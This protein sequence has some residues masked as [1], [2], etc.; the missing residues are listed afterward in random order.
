MLVTKKVRLFVDK[1]IHN[2]FISSAGCSRFSYNWAKNFSDEYYDKNS[3]TISESEIRKEFTIFKKT[4]GIEWINDVDNDILKQS[5]RDFCKARSMFF[6]GIH[7]IPKFKSKN[8]SKPSFYIDT[9]SIKIENNKVYVP[10]IGWIKYSTKSYKLPNYYLSKANK[11][12]TYIG[13]KPNN[14]R[15]TYD[16]RYW[17]LTL[18]YETSM[19]NEPKNNISIGVDLGLKTFATVYIN[20]LD[21]D[22]LSNEYYIFE[23]LKEKY[24]K[25]VKRKKRLDRK[26]SKRLTEYKKKGV[27]KSNNYEKLLK[28][29]LKLSNRMS[30]IQTENINQC[31][32]FMVKTKPLKIIIEDLNVAGMMKNKNLAKWISFNQFYTFRN[33]LT[34]KCSLNNIE[35]IIANRWFPSSKI[36]H[37]CGC[38]KDKLSL[39]ER[40]YVCEECREVIDRDLNAA[41]NLANYNK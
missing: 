36:C 40:T 32:N 15:V 14:P 23:S 16:G 34:F 22:E 35:L 33:K 39:S 41:I 26:I 19:I 2:K 4:P 5:I 17:N 1:E 11:T 24:K 30:N 7:G 20:N 18:A 10:K 29:R 28:K 27:T 25:L 21:Y 3:K 38:I 8:R 13:I 31:I 9:D 37:E 6:K 12:R